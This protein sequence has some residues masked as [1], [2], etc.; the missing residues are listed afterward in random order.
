M[1]G[2]GSVV[3]ILRNDKSYCGSIWMLS[4]CDICCDCFFLSS[5][6]CELSSNLPVCIHVLL[7][8]MRLGHVCRIVML[9]DRAVD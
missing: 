8:S 1:G 4:C 7:V 5:S 2:G 3:Y 9:K 6:V